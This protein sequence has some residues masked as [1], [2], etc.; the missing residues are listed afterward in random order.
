MK[1]RSMKSAVYAAGLVFA[2]AEDDPR[3]NAVAHAKPRAKRRV[4]KASEAY[5]AKFVEAESLQPPATSW[6]RSL[7]FSWLIGR[8][9]A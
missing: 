6:W 2:P 9:T 1:T 5:Q 4:S 8:A 7:D 3:T